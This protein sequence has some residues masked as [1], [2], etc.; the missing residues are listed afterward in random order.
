[1]LTHEQSSTYQSRAAHASAK[2]HLP[3][4]GLLT[5]PSRGRYP[6]LTLAQR[7]LALLRR[8]AGNPLV[9]GAVALA[10]ALPFVIGRQRKPKSSTSGYTVKP[11]GDDKISW[12]SAGWNAFVL[13]RNLHRRSERAAAGRMDPPTSPRTPPTVEHASRRAPT[14]GGKHRISLKSIYAL[15]KI[16]VSNWVDDFAPSMG[17][18]LSYYTVFSIAPLLVIVIAL[19]ALAF[20]Q[21]GAQS[22]ILDQIRGF[23]GPEGASAI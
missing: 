19:A 10:V 20:G 21:S 11:R 1:M 12:I 18:A 9:A 8:S 23:V 5:L 3:G 6:R 15:L 17:A 16:S 2:P 22:A 13:I 7:S 14:A 4:V